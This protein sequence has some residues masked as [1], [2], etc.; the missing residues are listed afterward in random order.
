M[1]R[2]LYVHNFRCLENFELLIADMPSSLLIGK[3]GSGKSTVGSALEVLQSLA[4]GT[5][6]V[7]QLVRPADFPRGRSGAPL[8]FEIEADIGDKVFEYVLALELPE[9]FK[10]LR[11]REER[12]SV[13]GKLIFSRESSQVQFANA[14]REAAANFLVDWHLAAL[15]VIQAQSPTDPLN[16]FKAWLANML[17]L[18]PIPYLI[19]GESEGETLFP[20]RQVKNFGEWFSGLLA[21]A[22]AAYT[23]I[24]KYLK[25]VMPDFKEFKN[26]FSGTDFRSLTIQF[27]QEGASLTLPLSGL[28]DGEKCFFV[29]AA[30]L[31]ANQASG[32][33][34]CFWD[35]P[36][37]YLSLKE[38]GHFV[39]TLRRS[40]QEQG[41]LLVTSH[42]PEAIRQFSDENTLLLYRRSHLEPTQIRPIAGLQE[43]IRGDL[44]GALIRDD[45]EP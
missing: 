33:F 36:D 10:E 28:S 12:L 9:G 38:V 18:A 37:N 32:P 7:S 41:Q 2:R 14:R 30:V 44:I 21:L 20:D 27:Q 3:N 31:A 39:M 5:N 40:F 24:D 15:P 25:G 23:Q 35:E 26:P 22:P 8:R 17:I 34:F 43:P 29:C 45:I 16:T 19:T 13:A 4:R 1:I 11:V 42:N 6:R